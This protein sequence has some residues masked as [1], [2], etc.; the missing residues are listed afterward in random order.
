MLCPN[1]GRRCSYIPSI[2]GILNYIPAF[3]E[4]CNVRR[5]TH[6]KAGSHLPIANPHTH[7]HNAE[8]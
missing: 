1:C 3:Q 6:I 8:V 2:V 5:T 7:D 4:W